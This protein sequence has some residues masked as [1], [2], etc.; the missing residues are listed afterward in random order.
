MQDIFEKEDDVFSRSDSD[1]L[2]PQNGLFNERD[3][4]LVVNEHDNLNLNLQQQICN[5]GNQF[6]NQLK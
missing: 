6:Y 5:K 2:N 3:E 1:V 4:H